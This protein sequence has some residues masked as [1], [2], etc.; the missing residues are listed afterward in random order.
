MSFRSISAGKS[1][2]EGASRMAIDNRLLARL[3]RSTGG[4][5]LDRAAGRL[6]PPTSTAK[7]KGTIGKAIAGA[8]ITRIAARSVPGAL[9]VGGGLLAKSL[10]DR[11]RARKEHDDAEL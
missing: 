3:V 1:K 11:R 9:L 2:R 4:K 7:S 8:A 6:F 5:L 10:Y